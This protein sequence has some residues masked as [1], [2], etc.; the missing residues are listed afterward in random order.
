[1]LRLAWLT[2]MKSERVVLLRRPLSQKRSLLRQRGSLIFFKELHMKHHLK[3]YLNIT[4][5]LLDI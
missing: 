3:T 2:A 5:F 1:M 4:V